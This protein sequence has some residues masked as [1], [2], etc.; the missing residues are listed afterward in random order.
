MLNTAWDFIVRARTWLLGAFAILIELGPEIL[1]ST[2]VLNAVPEK[3]RHVIAI[4][5]LIWSRWRF[6][7]RTADPEVQVKQAI[8]AA[9]YPATVII[10]AGGETKATIN[11]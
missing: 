1:G 11:A 10:E 2:E 6:A 7:T 8:K 5:L 4:G 3:W 9:D